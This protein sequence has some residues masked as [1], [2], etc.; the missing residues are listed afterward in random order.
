MEKVEIAVVK[1]GVETG[2]L[3]V[4]RQWVCKAEDHG[5]HEWNH[6]CYIR[7]SEVPEI[8]AKLQEWADTK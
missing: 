3:Q 6:T 7:K 4:I 5:T 2:K 1:V 8:I